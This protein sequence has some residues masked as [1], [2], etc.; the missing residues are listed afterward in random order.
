MRSAARDESQEKLIGQSLLLY[1]G[2]RG[3]CNYLK[4]LLEEAIE[5]VR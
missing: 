4:G 2:V 3:G 1:Q 5:R